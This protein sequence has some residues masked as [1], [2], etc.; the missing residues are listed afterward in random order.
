M[1]EAHLLNSCAAKDSPIYFC[2]HCVNV[3]TYPDQV[4]S[5]VLQDSW[6]DTRERERTDEVCL[7]CTELLTT[8]LHFH[9]HSDETQ[10]VWSHCISSLLHPHTHA[11]THMDTHA[12]AHRHAHAHTS[13]HTQ[14]HTHMH[15][16]THTHTHVSSIPTHPQHTRP[17]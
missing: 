13:E 5:Q 8:H 12:H 15:T 3:C 11:P 1:S 4:G 10:T 14:S 6:K 7:L 16:H 17:N 2:A 9:S